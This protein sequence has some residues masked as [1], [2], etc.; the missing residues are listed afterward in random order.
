MKIRLRVIGLLAAPLPVLALATAP[1]SAQTAGRAALG[2]ETVAA[3]S[4]A[5]R[6]GDLAATGQLSLEVSLAPRDEAGLQAFIGQVSNP[7]SPLYKHY[8]TVSQFADRF[9]AST[10]TIQSVTAYLR[11]AG[12]TVAAPTANHLTLATSGTTAQVEK[13]FGVTLANYRQGATGAE[14]FANTAAP[15]LPTALAAAVDGVAGLSDYAKHSYYA[16]P[17]K[18]SP[19]VTAN[20]TP[21]KARS[22][23]NLTSSISSGYNGTGETIGLVE[24]SAYSASDVAKYNSN[25]SLGASVPT[26]VKVSG[27]TTDTS[28]EVEDELDIEVANALAPKAAVA[29]YEAPNTDAGEVA[30]YAALVSK[31]VPV[32]SSSWGEPE[33]EEDNL[34]SDD[35]DFQE[36]AAQGQSVYAASGDSGADDN[37]SSLSV[38]YP[39]SDPYVAGTGGTDL[40]LT[41]SG[42]WSKETGWSD[43]GGGVS[44]EWATPSFQTKVNSGTHREVPDVSADADPSS[45]WYIYAEGGWEEVGGTSAAAPNWAAFTADYDT[46]ATH[47]SKAKFGFA[48]SFIYTV[49]ESSSYSTAFHDITSGNNGGYSAKTGYDEATGWGSYNGGGFIADEL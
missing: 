33:T 7:A 5:T 47:F 45:G 30:L 21:T 1:A 13:A 43:G 36:A 2:G 34:S 40:T 10:A 32:I 22:G 25:Y 24:F 4:Q 18:T 3:V 41:S 8:L 35:A 6:V 26:V 28:G 46:A 12:L 14:F 37:G 38:D 20:I 31:D 39:A 15:S 9:G 19:N 48:D 42:A 16:V 49:A 23:Y 44:V 17:A 11:S 27:G 29:V